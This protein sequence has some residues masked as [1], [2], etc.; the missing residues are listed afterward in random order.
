M[1]DR[2]F[3]IQD[4]C[5]KKG[6]LLNRPKQKDSSQFSEQDIAATRIHVECFIEEYVTGVS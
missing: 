2:G 5:A 6:I 4:F 1:S 3:S